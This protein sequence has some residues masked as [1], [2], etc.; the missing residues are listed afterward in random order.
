MDI[1]IPLIS[2]VLTEGLRHALAMAPVLFAVFLLMEAVSHG[3]RI[4]RTSSLLSHTV[5]GPVLAAGLGL[6][7]QCGFSVATTML[8]VGGMVPTGSLLA[9]YIATS[10]E[11]VPILVANSSTLHWVLPLLAT[12]MVWGSIVGIAVNGLSR[13]TKGLHAGNRHAGPHRH[14][15]L[16]R[17]SEPGTTPNSALDTECDAQANSESHT[18]SSSSSHSHS[19]SHSRSHSGSCVGEKA[20]A[21]DYVPHAA[22]RT[23]RTVA[24]VFV[25]SVILDLV[26]YAVEPGA[27]ALAMPGVWQPFAASVIGLFPSCATSV[28]LTEGFRA[29]LVSFPVL[30]SGLT[31]NSGMGLLVLMR[32]SRDARRNLAVVALLVVSA[33]AVGFL[34]QLF[35]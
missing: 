24:M 19:R 2:D 20:R 11:A 26:G 13:A 29:G 31:A 32:E 12:K 17:Y 7:P 25:L 10:D 23:A 5:L 33:S 14:A 18:H 27:G 4:G 8:Y 1:D 21:R 30:I 16:C 15:A 3:A 9:S 34:A 28:A 6:L 22:Y 35:F